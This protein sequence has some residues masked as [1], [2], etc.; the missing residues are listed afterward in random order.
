MVLSLLFQ[1]LLKDKSEFA[2]TVEIPTGS[3]LDMVF[4]EKKGQPKCVSR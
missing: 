1:L 3:I 4:G 2:F